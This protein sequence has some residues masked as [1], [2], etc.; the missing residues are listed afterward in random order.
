MRYFKNEKKKKKNFLSK[1][2]HIYTYVAHNNY[3]FKSYIYLIIIIIIIIIRRKINIKS[4][5][6]NS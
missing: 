5:Y 6:K 4:K 3:Y 1:L 2:K